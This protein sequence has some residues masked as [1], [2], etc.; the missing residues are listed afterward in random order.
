MRIH[1]KIDFHRFVGISFLLLSFNIT[2]FGNIPAPLPEYSGMESYSEY[3]GTVVDKKTGTPLAF[4]NIS[5]VGTNIS[6][7]SNTE[8]EFSLKISRESTDTKVLVSFIGYKSKQLT[9]MELSN[10]NLKIP[11]ELTSVEL[12]EIN[13]I[14]KDAEALMRAVLDKKE[15][16]YFNNPLLMTAF[17]RETI[18]KNRNYVSLSE[19]VV[20]INKQPVNS[21]RSDIVKLYKAR[22][23]A[24]Y[25]KLD[26]I[27]FK[28]QG[29]PFNSLYLD[30]MKN[31]EMIFTEDM[32]KNYEFSFDRSTHMDNRLI[33]IIDFKQHSEIKEPLYHGKLYIDAQSLALKSA[34]FN[35]NISN[36]EEA[37]RMFIVKKPFN[38]R[39]Y[40]FET[41]YRIDYL[42]KDGKWYYGYSRIEFGLK[43]NWKKKLF[44][45]N[46]YST[47]EMAVTDWEKL[48]DNQIER[49]ERLHPNVIISDEASGFS[50]PSFWGEYNVIE[51]EKSIE[52][53]IK[54]IQ[55]QLEKEQELKK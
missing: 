7:V 26:T 8:G 44:N 31:P 34:I 51:P 20:E 48:T 46:Y 11:L 17:Y 30:I 45:T 50:E 1:S 6:T 24:D 27:T 39:A 36:K 43:I 15:Q 21:Y 12:P 47:I 53:A 38:A 14:S 54:K 19:A 52:S 25:S 35:M 2:L 10:E 22:K 41:N 33:F 18:K 3:K 9:L 42:E 13:V 23:N 4:A 16:N 5:V 29:G 32:F 37:A 55:K 40:P 49:K 28:L